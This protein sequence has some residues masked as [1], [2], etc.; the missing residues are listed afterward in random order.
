MKAEP[1]I[2]QEL[3]HGEEQDMKVP[4]YAPIVCLGHRQLGEW[5]LCVS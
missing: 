5:T 2:E 1:F 4:T 3:V